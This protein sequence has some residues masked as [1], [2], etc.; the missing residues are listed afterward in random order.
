MDVFGAN[1][2]IQPIRGS[3]NGPHLFGANRG[4]W[5]STDCLP[6]ARFTVI[7][8]AVITYNNKSIILALPTT[9]THTPAT[10]THTPTTSYVKQY[11]IV[12]RP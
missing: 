1:S 7:L 5:P 2:E 6:Y 9:N 3:T 11:I 4:S 8:L 10:K 12:E